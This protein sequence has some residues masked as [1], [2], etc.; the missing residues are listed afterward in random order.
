MFGVKFN[1]QIF[2]FIRLTFDFVKK[3]FFINKTN[4]S[5]VFPF[6]AASDLEK[7]KEVAHF[8]PSQRGS[9][10]LYYDGRRFTRDG[11]FADSTNWRCCYFRDKCRARAIT[12]QVNG[13]I[14]VRITNPNHT[15][16]AKRKRSL[17]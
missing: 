14:R 3:T 9:T 6:I 13:Q 10:V 7:Y 15:C 17:K 5:F 8:E 4:R 12:K 16:S 2:L 11:M 1:F